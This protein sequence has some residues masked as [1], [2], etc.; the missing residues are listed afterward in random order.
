MGLRG[1]PEVVLINYSNELV[2]VSLTV[3]HMTTDETVLSETV[4]LDVEE[5]QSY[6]NL[7]QEGVKY[8]IEV[9][10]DE[11]RTDSHEWTNRDGRK[12]SVSIRDEEVRISTIVR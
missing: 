4:S 1:W 6:R 8:A 5:S 12:L 11:D 2:E 10:V 3:N 9:S 7:L